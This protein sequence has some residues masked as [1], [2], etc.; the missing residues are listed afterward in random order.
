MASR[1]EKSEDS[2]SDAKN[3][4]SEYLRQQSEGKPVDFDGFCAQHPTLEGSLR[5]IHE[6]V[7]LGRS[8]ATSR[9][10]HQSVRERFGDLE[11]VTILLESSSFLERLAGEESRTSGPAEIRGRYKPST[12]C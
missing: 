1:D 3:A 10:F 9:S 2:L 8:L 12:R 5:S 11:D 7:Q 4:Y 6:C